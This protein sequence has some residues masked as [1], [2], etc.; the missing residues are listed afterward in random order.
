MESLLL[1]GLQ[2]CPGELAVLSGAPASQAEGE[3]LLLL[4][5]VWAWGGVGDSGPGPRGADLVAA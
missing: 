5:V 1:A 4:A 3:G 2:G